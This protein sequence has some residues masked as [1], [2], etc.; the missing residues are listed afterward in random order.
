MGEN[1]RLRIINSLL[2]RCVYLA[3]VASGGRAGMAGPHILLNFII[4]E[5]PK[6]R[7]T[8]FWG[9]YNKGSCYSR[10]Y[11][12]VP[13]FRKLPYDLLDR[14]Q[15]FIILGPDLLYTPKAWVNLGPSP[16][17]N[18]DMS[19]CWGEPKFLCAKA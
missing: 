15:G 2:V 12:R 17:R 4:R 9:P 10:D 6:I 3:F 18:S 19:D 16:L 13:Y 5:F 14:I 8:L 1:S 11:I 7:G